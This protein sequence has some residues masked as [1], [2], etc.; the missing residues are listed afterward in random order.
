MPADPNKTPNLELV[1][2]NDFLIS[3]LGNGRCALKPKLR[4]ELRTSLVI[5]NEL[6][7]EPTPA[8]KLEPNFQK[9]P[10]LPKI[11]KIRVNPID[12]RLNLIN[13]FIKKHL[14][15]KN[16]KTALNHRVLTLNI[17]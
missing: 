1:E 6:I 2:K 12:I 14:I 11:G 3:T 13:C 5:N 15:I 7:F 8:L 9:L 4:A 10:G 16:L 17:N